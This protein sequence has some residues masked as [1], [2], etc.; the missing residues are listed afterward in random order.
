MSLTAGATLAHYHVT[1]LLG[2]GGMG[3]VWQATDTQLN[4]QVALKILPD[5]F[6]DDPDRLARFQRE[7]QL[8]A[9]LNHPNIGGIHGLEHSGGVRALVLELIEGPT[10]ADR[11]AQ[12]PIPLDEALPIA[13]QIAEALEA[14]HEAGVIHRDL[15]PANIKVRD[16][17]TVKVLD[18]G[19]AKALDPTPAG[20]PDLSPTLTAAATQMG[21]ILGTAAYMS[22]EQAR[23]KPVDRR[24]DIWAF[25][26][27][28]YEMLTGRRAF[29][30]EDVSMTLSQVLQREPDFGL[31]P[32]SVSPHVA[33]TMRLCLRKDPQQRLGDVRDARLALDG[34]FE[35]AVS[36][37]VGAVAAPQRL[38]W[39][40]PIVVACAMMLAL[41]AGLAVSRLFWA[42]AQPSA[43]PTRLTLTVPDT[44]ALPSTPL[45]PV[46]ALSPDGRTLVYRAARNG[47]QQLFRRPIDQFEATPIPGT[48]DSTTAFFSPDGQ[49]VGFDP[50]GGLAKVALAGGPAQTLMDVAGAFGGIRGAD[51]AAD[52]T[53]VFGSSRPGGPLMQIPAAGGE[54]TALF[55]P[56]DRRRSAQPQVIVERDAV[57]FSLSGGPQDTSELQVLYRETGAR[58]T[59]V[60]NA[61]AGRVLSTG[62]L[63]F[64]RSGALWAVPIDRTRLEI[65]GTPTPVVEGVRVDVS[66][67][68]HYATGD[69]GSLVY[70]PGTGSP[71][72]RS[73]VWV[74]R[75]GVE[76]VLSL[77]S[78]DY[79]TLSLSPDGLRAAVVAGGSGGNRDIWVAE[80]A[81][82]TLTRLTT[83]PGD[84][85]HP[86]W[87]PDGRR[88]AFVSHEDGRATLYWQPADGSA[89]PERLLSDERLRDLVPYDWSPDGQT[90]FLTADSSETGRDIVRVSTDGSGTWEPLFQTPANEFSPAISPD[91]RW[92]AYASTESGRFELYVQRFPEL[93]GR[94]QI[95]VGG[96]YRPH[97][98]ADGRELF[99][100]RA[101]NAPPTAVVR[102]TVETTNSDPPVLVF[103]TEEVLFDWRYYAQPSPMQYYDLSPDGQRFLVIGTGDADDVGAGRDEINVVLDW[104]QELLERVPIP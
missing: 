26:C 54:P 32:P 79:D 16:N 67:A 47:V 31:L 5:A 39:Q 60:S 85:T 92:L 61:S 49:W 56:E 24:A 14:A 83:H 2:E 71:D 100:L 91:G 51:W 1:A 70:I 88:V 9:S 28:L 17:G 52:D 99:Y 44:D 75:E 19:L 96:G 72:S 27:V 42:T 94:Q 13:T 8:L 41:A 21:V 20:N 89:P 36:P 95:S 12:G 34:A 58:R 57:I 6:A 102:V 101:P 62:H 73:L 93:Q 76:E 50:N 29:A 87:T 104:H 25:G 30:G 10:L 81:R 48:E 23:G 35:T 84:D 46:I 77:P 68:V 55:T 63:V 69:D 43:G 74:D 45:G 40:R 98:S 103:G 65:V 38:V 64:V 86:L 3:Q 7:A 22:P 66:G 90:L 80:L 37:A 18:F 11:I 78:R 15:K 33:Q 4:R 82:G 53:I 59:L 97:W